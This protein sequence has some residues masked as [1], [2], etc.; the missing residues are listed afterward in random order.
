MAKQNVTFIERHVEK[1]VLGLTGAVVLATAVMY[2]V[3]TPHS[4]NSGGEE[5]TPKTLIG[6]ITEQAEQTRQRVK[7]ARETDLAADRIVGPV[8][9][10]LSVYDA[11]NIPK[12]IPVALVPP[13]VP[14]PLGKDAGMVGDKIRLATVAAPRSLAVF[15]GRVSA[16]LASPEIVDL[17]KTTAGAAPAAPSMGADAI[18][19]VTRDIFWATVLASVHFAEQRELFSQ[20]KYE[21]TRQDLI[22]AGVE[23]ERAPLL[24]SGEWGKPELV[25]GYS[26]FVLSA[27]ETV[28]LHDADGTLAIQQ[29][30]GETILAYRMALEQIQN[31]EQILRPSFFENFTEER[32]GWKLP[33][34]L[35]GLELDLA[36]FMGEQAVGGRRAMGGFGPG[37]MGAF[38][39]GPMGRRGGLPIE[40]GGRRGPPGG[41]PDFLAPP[42]GRGGP[43]A[44]GRRTVGAEGSPEARSPGARAEIAKMLKEAKDD[45]DKKKYLE[46]EEKLQNLLQTSIGGDLNKS[47]LDEINRLRKE[48]QPEVEAL[49]IQKQKEERVA[50]ATQN[51]MRD[52]ELLWFNDI[53]V[54]PGQTYRY[55]LRLVVFN[56]YIGQP[57]RLLDPQDAGK[58]VIRGQWSDW[59]EP[60]QVKPS[61]YLFVTSVADDGRRAKVALR[62]WARGE[63]K[64]GTADKELGE[65]VALK[66]D[67]RDLSY[68]AILA[69]IEPKRS[70][71]LRAGTKEGKLSF[72]ERQG[73]A[74]VLITMSG[75]VEER[76]VPEDARRIGQLDKEYKEEQERLSENDPTAAQLRPVRP[77]APPN[78]ADRG[79]GPE[80]TRPNRP[81]GM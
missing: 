30:D 65:L 63:L 59:S 50:V 37:P 48:I 81:R 71:L 31:Q 60:I 29:S 53:S 78:P 70:R 67:R 12:E 68:D 6:K 24:P 73:A 15:S 27:P 45:I 5:H 16:R 28:P 47:Q 20:A 7:N 41:V 13:G 64:G 61:L 62:E 57:T 44:G 9:G 25:K 77:E 69:G 75:E 2:V 39:P 58:V 1:M 42:G 49:I 22:V 38:G 4:V 14:I 74:A 32:F 23:A 35:P 17:T 10:D 79:R 18:I 72:T 80:R 43:A 19:G 34:A 55:R 51:K 46:A 56:Q 8:K 26:P 36:Q 54:T 3:G 66:A 40:G 11:N 33:K 52:I 21:A 76:F